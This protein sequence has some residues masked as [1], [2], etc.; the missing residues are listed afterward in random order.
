[1]LDQRREFGEHPIERVVAVRHD[2]QQLVGGIDGAGDV[3][4]LLG[5]V[6]GEG[7]QLAEEVAD[8]VARPSRMLMTSVWMHFEVRDAAATQDRWRYW[9]ASVRWWGRP[10]EFFSGM[11]SPFL[12]RLR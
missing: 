4:A 8:L 5:S 3:V 12:Q 11:V 9:P 7:V 2:R 1:M 6:G 10:S